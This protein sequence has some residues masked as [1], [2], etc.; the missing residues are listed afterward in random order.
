[1]IWRLD[2]MKIWLIKLEV[3]KYNS[4]NGYDVKEKL[5]VN[6]YGNNISD[7]WVAPSITAYYKKRKIAD[8]SS[9]SNG[10]PLFNEKTI[11]VLEEFLKDKA[12]LLPVYHEKS[13][14]YVVNIINVIDALDYEKSE[15]E[16]FDTGAIMYCTKYSFKPEIVENQ[17]LFK[18]PLCNSI[19]IFVSDDFKKKVEE[20][21]IKGLIFVEAWNSEESTSIDKLELDNG[22]S[23][24]IQ[25]DLKSTKL[26]DKTLK[27]KGK[28]VYPKISEVEAK[29]LQL[30]IIGNLCDVV[31]Q[32]VKEI[33][34]EKGMI[35]LIGLEYFFDGQYTDI[36]VRINLLI[37]STEGEYEELYYQLL[38][39][40]NITFDF[41]SLYSY[42]V[43]DYMNE[44]ETSLFFEVLQELIL[45]LNERIQDIKWESIAEVTKE[46]SI[47]VPKL[48][49]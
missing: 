38:N 21:K 43:K 4:F 17:H 7:K 24:E 28:E 35:D 36:G 14:Y 44:E 10:A 25:A 27:A 47:E 18:I 37:N 42:Y 5:S 11:D 31:V 2:A 33:P 12:E 3:D 30:E 34:K 15:F 1:M 16:R 20:T 22:Q 49:D 46:F 13:K 8:I 19:D 41:N 39:H 9:F 29:N 32:Y 23:E 6:F 26:Q 45:K 40:L 48:Y